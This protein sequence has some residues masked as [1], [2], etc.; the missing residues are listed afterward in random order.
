M[1][2]I[3][4]LSACVIACEPETDNFQRL[5]SERVES[6][7][8]V[9]W[10]NIGP[11]MSGYNEK[12]WPH[13]LDPD[14]MFIGPDMHV[15]YGTWDGG[16]TWQ[17]IQDHD[18][19]GQLMKR[20][21]DIEFS[22]Q[23]PDF[24]MA[25]DWNGW[26]YQTTDMGH[27][28]TKIAELS[29]GYTDLGVDPYDTEAFRKGWYDEQIGKRLGELAVD[30]TNDEIW[31][32]GAGDFWNVKENHRSAARPQ[33]NRLSYA[34]Y[35]YLLKS[36]DKG[37]TWQKL[38]QGFPPDLDV[39][40]I[41]VNP[42]NPDHLIMVTNHGL[43]HSDDGGSVWR[44]GAEGLPNNRP[45][46]LTAFFDEESREFVLY[47]VE[48]THYVAAGDSVHSIG[49]IFKSVDSGN[50]WQN[51]TGDL[52]IDLTQI[53]YPEE[54]DR[55]F[56]TLGNW[57]GLDKASALKQFPR[58]PR[59][60][61][62]V[63]N[64]IAVNPRNR[65]EIYVTYNKKHDRTFG[66][67]DV[68]RTLNGGQSWQVVARHG[69]YWLSGKDKEYWESRGNPT[70]ANVDF[71]HVQAHMDAQYEKEGNRLLA[72]NPAGDVFISIGQQTHTSTDKGDSWKQI[73]DIE[74][75]P[76]TGMWIGRG[77]SDLPGRFMLHETG[78]RDRRLFASGE[79]GVW[80][81]VVPDDWPDKQ[82]VALR[83]IEGQNN[84]DGMVS[85]STIAVHPHDPDIIYLLAWRQEHKGKLR[86]S[87]D[88]GKTWHNIATVLEVSDEPTDAGQTVVS[89][90]PGTVIQGPPG[91]LPAQNSLLID[92]V[93]PENMYFVATRMAFSEVYRAPRREPTLGG[94]GF[95]KSAD[96]GYTWKL[97][98]KGFHEG[99]SL[100]RIALDPDS[101]DTIL[102]AANDENGGLYRSPDRGESWERIEIPE[103]IKSVNNIFIDKITGH[104][105]I[106]AGGFYQGAYEEGGAWRS[107]DAGRSWEQIFKAPVVLQV[108]S[109]PVDSSILL[110]TAGNQ[111]RMDR[112]F[113][114]PGLFLSLDA[115][116]SWKKINRDL[117]NNDK[118]IDA[119][120]DPYNSNVLW[121]AGWG[122]GWY[123]G[124][125]NG[126]GGKGWSKP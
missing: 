4:M 113:M 101:P 126:A 28:W 115:G 23:D 118:I 13:P 57:F 114:N 124:Y 50:T 62:P 21:I 24:A 79:H 64:R 10:R 123:V 59:S 31:Y 45:R 82:A 41:V 97:S 111:M 61:L 76:G 92:P 33:G 68:W 110:L 1:I 89:E 95:F 18:E 56:R 15:A 71:A 100:R 36:T 67:G 16:R 44:T 7:P 78:V 46:D 120:P 103:V 90:K 22:L 94:F 40:R 12:L 105:Y 84:I 42:L 8:I 17:S 39:G 99:C 66:P 9:A 70:G 104:W 87:K 122:S 58:L 52:P 14:V 112:Q 83:Q 19:L 91:L 121:A 116:N 11:G 43:M 88:G 20:V 55:Y 38:D 86:R 98:N 81:T 119:K 35:G 125:I 109:S 26:V 65:D 30:P 32:T 72:I 73:D 77:N 74:T 93:S 49:G 27:S 5:R 37:K 108:E 60:I 96:A 85:I 51:I 25:L 80:E 6:E 63:F 53:D 75:A 107:R 3:C 102:A 48:Q 34:D 29:P 117:A 47:L 54:T 106:S 69:A 2:A